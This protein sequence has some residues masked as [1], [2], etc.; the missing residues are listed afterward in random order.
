MQSLALC[1]QPE[2]TVSSKD[3]TFLAGDDP[4]T[5]LCPIHYR[6]YRG[7]G[8]AKSSYSTRSCRTLYQD[9][10]EMVKVVRPECLFSKLS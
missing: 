10:E 2:Y 5:I 6:L 9:G 8:G 7:G 4:W 1:F 3:K